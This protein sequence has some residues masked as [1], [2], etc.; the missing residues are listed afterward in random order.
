MRPRARADSS[1][2]AYEIEDDRRSVMVWFSLAVSV[3]ARS[4]RL[5]ARSAARPAMPVILSDARLYVS[6]ARRPARFTEPATCSRNSAPRRG[7]RKSAATAPTAIPHIIPVR[8]APLE[9]GRS[10]YGRELMTTSCGDTPRSTTPQSNRHATNSSAKCDNWSDDCNA[11]PGEISCPVH[12]E[13]RSFL[14]FFSRHR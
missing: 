8:K 5:P 11:P 7:A 4:V 10:S 9:L 6:T 2:D 13:S 3:A 1:R 14:S 12:G